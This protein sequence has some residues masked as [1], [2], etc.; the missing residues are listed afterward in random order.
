MDKS[1]LFLKLIFPVSTF[2]Q[3]YFNSSRED[4]YPFE[5]SEA[6]DRQLKS[7]QTILAQSR[8]ALQVN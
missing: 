7:E 4:L 2:A 1:I 3:L 5:Y 8:I 6:F